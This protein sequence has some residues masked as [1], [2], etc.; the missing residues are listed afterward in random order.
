MYSTIAMT[1][2]LN[3]VC[4]TQFFIIEIESGNVKVLNQIYF[5]V[6]LRIKMPQVNAYTIVCKYSAKSW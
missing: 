3:A 5:T 1:K 4:K 2:W 6:F